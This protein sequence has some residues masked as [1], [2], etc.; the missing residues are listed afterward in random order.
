MAVG[1]RVWEALTSSY[2][3]S[4]AIHSSDWQFLKGC[5]LKLPRTCNQNKSTVTNSK[6]DSGLRF[7]VLEKDHWLMLKIY[8]QA[9]M[10]AKGSVKKGAARILD[11][12][13]RVYSFS[14]SLP[15]L[16]FSASLPVTMR[17]WE[18]LFRKYIRGKDEGK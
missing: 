11:S 16:A 13:K 5:S 3:P 4:H 17:A 2:P 9:P 12:P 7:E 15:P 6:A 10:S 18:L 1:A 8:K 14:S